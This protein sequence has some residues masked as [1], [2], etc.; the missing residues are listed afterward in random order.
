[1]ESGE[2]VEFCGWN[3]GGQILEGL[4]QKPYGPGCPLLAGGFRTLPQGASRRFGAGFS[5]PI[6]PTAAPS[7]LSNTQWRYR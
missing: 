4:T 6:R 3:E 1:M 5:R 7:R 2:R